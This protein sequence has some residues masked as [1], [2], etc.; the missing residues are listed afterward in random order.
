M[1]AKECV[2]K[3]KW[4]AKKRESDPEYIE[5]VKCYD[6]KRK[7]GSKI[8]KNTSHPLSPPCTPVKSKT[9][10]YYKVLTKSMKIHQ[11]LGPSLKTN[12]SIL[13][14]VL[15]KT[16]KSPRKSEHLCDTP[17]TVVK[18]HPGASVTY[19]TPLKDVTK[20]L[21]KVAVLKA[22]Q[23]PEKA[24]KL[25]ESLKGQFRY[26]KD[27]AKYVGDDEKA[28]YRLLSPPKRRIKEEYIWKLSDEVKAE[29]EG[30]YND[31]EVMYCLPDMKLSGLKFMSC[32]PS[33]AHR[34]YLAKCKTK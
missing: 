30:I 1:R 34:L 18:L 31:P 25:S 7:Q 24:R 14:H 21:Q 29:V 8:T 22:K 19:V 16:M 33:E 4:R 20:H 13:K 23:Q 17:S 2:R 5:K 15:K 28:I 9:P 6:R 3:A 11:I 32:T 10:T 27:I 26:I 12:T